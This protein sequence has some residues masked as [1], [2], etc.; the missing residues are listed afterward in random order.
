MALSK[1]G[2]GGDVGSFRFGDRER[3]RLGVD[4]K[5]EAPLAIDHGR[6]RRFPH[7]GPLGAGNDMPGLDAIDIGRDRDDPVRVMAREIGVDA[8]DRYRLRFLL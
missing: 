8:A 3:H 2:A 1:H 4:V 6:G 5:A 7:N